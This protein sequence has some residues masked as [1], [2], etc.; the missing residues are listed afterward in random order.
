MSNKYDVIEHDIDDVPLLEVADRFHSDRLLF[1]KFKSLEGKVKDK[2]YQKVSDEESISVGDRKKI[3]I[4]TL[5]IQEQK[6]DNMESAKKLCYSLGMNPEMYKDTREI[7]AISP[8]HDNGLFTYIQYNQQD[9]YISEK[10]KE[11]KDLNESLKE[12]LNKENPSY[13]ELQASLEVVWSFRKHLEDSLEKSKSSLKKEVEEYMVKDNGFTPQEENFFL[14]MNQN[15]TYGSYQ[16]HIFS[17]KKFISHVV[18]IGNSLEHQDRDKV[19]NKAYEEMEKDIK[20]STSNFILINH[21]SSLSEEDK[22]SISSIK[23]S[24][25]PE[26]VYDYL[27]NNIEDGKVLESINDYVNE[28]RKLMED[29][30]P[31]DYLANSIK[32]TSL[33]VKL[34]PPRGYKSLEAMKKNELLDNAGE[35]L[36]TIR[37]I[38]LGAKTTSLD[39]IYKKFEE[40]EKKGVRFEPFYII[41]NGINDEEK[42]KKVKPK[43]SSFSL[44][45]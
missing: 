9:N 4:F 23:S 27:L 3:G 16:Q 44:S 22:Q 11:Y 2:I 28:Q 8:R 41:N 33:V 38:S 26:K 29:V 10:S 24:P 34:D 6:R 43:T 32:K 18:E 13:D 30:D 17:P 1:K 40:S 5:Q 14:H 45:Q 31:V 21:Y 37:D 7:T 25:E 15:V 42:E 35:A 20:K 36:K 39:E 19:I 12:V